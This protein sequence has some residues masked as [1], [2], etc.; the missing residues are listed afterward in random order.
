MKKWYLVEDSYIDAETLEEAISNFKVEMY[1]MANLT[2]S[3]NGT[4]YDIWIDNGGRSRNVPHNSPRI[5]FNLD[6]ELIP[7]SIDRS[8]PQILINI[9]KKYINNLDKIKQFVIKN[10]DVLMKHHN[11]EISD[12]EALNSLKRV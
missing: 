4:S 2:S 6:G 3:E 5:K 8:N 11:G 12:K 7:V 1:D 10:Y 9:D